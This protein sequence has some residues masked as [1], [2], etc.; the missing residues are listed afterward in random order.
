[1]FWL[2]SSKHSFSLFLKKISP[3]IPPDRAGSDNLFKT[4][5]LEN[6]HRLQELL[7]K[8]EWTTEDKQW[9]LQYLESANNDELFQLQQQGFQQ[10]LT[11][12]QQVD[13]A[14]TQ[15]LLH[16]IH[17]QAEIPQKQA[18]VRR[19]PV[20]IRRV[21]AAAII[22]GLLAG[23]AWYW[24]SQSSTPA[25]DSPQVAAAHQQ[26]DV[27][28]GGNKAILTFDN[29]TRIVLDDASNG[30]LTQQGNTS[31]NKQDGQLIYNNAAKAQGAL[32]IQGIPVYNTIHTPR[33]GQYSIL[34]A[35]GSKVWLNAAS[36][37]RYP[38]TFSGSTRKVEITGEA[39]FEVAHNTAQPFI[40]TVRTKEGE[41]GEIKV[42]GTHFN[43]N[44]YDDEQV[45]STTLLEGSV[46]MRTNVKGEKSDAKDGSRILAPGQQA[47]IS[48][49]FNKSPKIQVQTVDVETVVAWKNGFFEFD[50]NTIQSVMRQV[51]RWY[52]V[53]VVYEGPLPTAN[54]VGT[55]SRQENI[56]KVL[57]MLALTNVIQFRIQ[58]QNAAGEAAKIIVMQK[59]Q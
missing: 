8:K 44:A 28:P 34:L 1:M 32:T 6:L 54:F 41:T 4:L 11:S 52:D 16:A 38:I 45:M 26:P 59:K 53:D 51:S 46:E 29:G 15:R 3:P 13:P 33:G 20:V 27:L 9:L 58:E 23:G 36:S 48:T 10:Q 50:G 31:I 12:N 21:A 40:V 19:L 43:V 2:P 7:Q 24:L 57:K 25:K 30:P 5:L 55:I 35:D 49:Q 17:D 37:M 39:Y 47:F 42:L 56:S 18:P 22:A 14:V